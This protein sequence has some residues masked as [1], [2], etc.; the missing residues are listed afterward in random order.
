MLLKLEGF[1]Y[2]TSIDL[3]I[4]YCYT[5]FG[6]VRE[7]KVKKEEGKRVWGGPE[8]FPPILCIIHLRRVAQYKQQNLKSGAGHYISRKRLDLPSQ[9]SFNK[10]PKKE[11]YYRQTMATTT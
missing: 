1:Q 11:G 4:R 2:A 8:L 5:Y 9:F 10:R 6:R 3:N 7:Q